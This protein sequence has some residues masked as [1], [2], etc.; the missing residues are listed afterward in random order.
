MNPVDRHSIIITIEL[1]GIESPFLL[2]NRH[3]FH[4]SMLF[5]LLPFSFFFV[6]TLYLCVFVSDFSSIQFNPI[7][8][9][10]SFLHNTRTPM[11]L[12][13]FFSF[14]FP[15]VRPFFR[16]SIMAVLIQSNSITS[17]REEPKCHLPACLCLCLSALF[18]L[19]TT[20]ISHFAHPHPHKNIACFI[21]F[22]L[23]PYARDHIH[24]TFLV[25][26]RTLLI[27]GTDQRPAPVLANTTIIPP[28]RV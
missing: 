28:Q 14:F 2:F 9:F 7:H 26:T 8:S 23:V 3:L 5:I 12:F 1:D 10:S 25:F 13:F 16:S 19:T 27:N 24:V 6:P 18:A 17:N 4:S 15:L 11:I 20:T 22:S 21:F